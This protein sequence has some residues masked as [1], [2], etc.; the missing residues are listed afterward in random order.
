M[1][2]KSRNI[3]LQQVGLSAQRTTVLKAKLKNDSYRIVR[4]G[5]SC[6]GEVVP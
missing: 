3:M 1:T 5:E 2:T 6:D 4:H